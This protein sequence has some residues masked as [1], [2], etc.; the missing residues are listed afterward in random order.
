MKVLIK[1]L[2]VLAVIA[3]LLVAGAQ[4]FL[5]RGLTGALNNAV[6]PAVKS[7]YG[8]E[9]SIEKASVNLFAGKADLGGFSVRNLKGFEAPQLFGFR[10]CLLDINMLSLI[11]HDPVIVTRT[12]ISGAR[13]IVERNDKKQI[14][15]QMLA[16]GIK[17]IESADQDPDSPEPAE[18]QTI[19]MLPLWIQGAILDLEIEYFDSGEQ[20]HYTFALR[21]TGR[22][23]FIAMPNAEQPNSTFTLRGS[24]ADD[25]NAFAT[26]LKAELAP[27]IDPG[28]PTFRI[29]GRIL[30][31]DSAFINRL[32]ARNKIQSE[33]FTLNP[34]ITCRNGNLHGSRI[35][36]ILENAKIYD[37][38]VDQ[39]KLPLMLGGHWRS[40]RITNFEKTLSAAFSAQG[41]KIARAVA[42]EKLK[43]ETGL[44][45]DA[46]VSELITKQLSESFEEVSEN[47][48]LQRLIQK[49]AS[50][51]LK[52]QDD[53]SLSEGLE[54]LLTG[55]QKAGTTNKNTLNDSLFNQTN[56]DTLRG[57]SETL[58]GE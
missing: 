47:P 2:L 19:P 42:L 38:S 6:F 16:E 15:V 23:V 45:A 10:T 5:S 40:P 22:N 57:L 26:D 52:S 50:D 21:G 44:D 13:L 48:A 37:T 4:L 8:L 31:I 27:I 14:N 55:R 28:N 41:A 53:K 12:E 32:L 18:E 36:L 46:N 1:T 20:D 17:P 49:T 9:L 54:K 56:D 29:I 34:N 24:L 30:D 33:T 43:E 25:E 7:I 11:K 3:V 58:L 39:I 35:E 51:F